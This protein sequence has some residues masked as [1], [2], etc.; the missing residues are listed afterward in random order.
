VAFPLTALLLST[1][2][3][4]WYWHSA[5][6]DSEVRRAAAAGSLL[7]IVALFTLGSIWPSIFTLAA[8]LA[9]PAAFIF[10]WSFFRPRVLDRPLV[11]V[12]TRVSV[13]LPPLSFALLVL[14]RIA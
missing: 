2:V 3:A 11:N 5:S 4:A 13:L 12:Y 14:M 1:L 9:F 7:S 10:G 6:G 8:A